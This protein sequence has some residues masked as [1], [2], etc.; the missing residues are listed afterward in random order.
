MGVYR[1]ELI[2]PAPSKHNPWLPF[3]SS[4]YDLWR[5][6]IILCT[7]C[8]SMITLR[9]GAYFTQCLWFHNCNIY[10]I[11]FTVILI[12]MIQSALHSAHVKTYQPE[13]VLYMRSVNVNRLSLAECIQRMVPDQ[14][15][16]YF[17]FRDMI[18]PLLYKVW[19]QFKAYVLWDPTPVAKW[20][21][22]HVDEILLMTYMY[23]KI[24]LGR[25]FEGF[26][27]NFTGICFWLS[28]KMIFR[29]GT[30]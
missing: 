27:S 18:G 20:I 13:I 3:T 10:G 25:K 26:D 1:H 21:P 29:K 12:L 7:T 30:F 14:L 28:Q 11:F 22:D 8:Q 23:I 16:W 5:P 19:Y 9:P 2:T 24:L 4:S 15:S 17:Q 6:W